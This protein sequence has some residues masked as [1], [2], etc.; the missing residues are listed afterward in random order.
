MV[1]TERTA[2]LSPR[3]GASRLSLRPSFLA[4]SSPAQVPDVQAQVPDVNCTSGTWAGDERGVT[5]R[6]TRRCE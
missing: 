6:S 4:L 5:H 3:Y 1:P 2:S